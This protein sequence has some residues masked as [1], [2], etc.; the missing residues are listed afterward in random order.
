MTSL[1]NVVSGSTASAGKNL[2]DRLHQVFLSQQDAFR[3]NPY[4]SAAERRS[5]LLA[6]KN[7]LSR[8]QN[9]LAA[10]MSSD[11]GFRP[12]MESKLSDLLGSILEIN[13]LISHVGQWMKPSR[14]SP[15]HLFLTNSLTVVYQ[16]KGVVG[17]IVPWN[18]PIYLA[19]GP[20][21]SALAA[22]NRVM[23]KMPEAAPTTGRVLASMLREIFSEEE[24]AVVYTK[25]PSYDF[26]TSLPFNHIVFTGSPPSGKMVMKAAAEHLT[27]VTLELG[28]KSPAVVGRRYSTEDAARR[29]VHGK[30]LNCGQTCV[31]PDFAMVPAELIDD[32]VS[33]AKQSFSRLAGAAFSSGADY[34]WIINENRHARVLALLDD[35]QRKG[36]KVIPCADYSPEKDGRRMPLHLV[37]NCSAD[38]LILQEELF[39]PIL[40]VLAYSALD[41]VLELIATR[42]RPLALYLFSNDHDEQARFLTQTHSGGVTLNDWLCHVVNHDAPFGGVGNSGMGTYHGIEGFRE[43]S[44]AKTVFKLHRLFPTQLF[45]PPYGSLVQRFALRWFLGKPD[46]SLGAD[47]LTQKKGS[48]GIDSTS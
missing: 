29:I 4:P 12:P 16:P 45:H 3:T 17:I 1:S 25:L 19:L 34:T 43:L 23:M 5:K 18:F 40:P 27:P 20:L 39:G 24:V 36:A 21:A 46:E 35:A 33:A 42:P 14:R 26:F 48:L 38:M 31:A 7:Q 2:A 47:G 10:A 6:L 9:V 41:D 15:E 13:H 37:L 30:Y 8:Y 44:H 32:F 28:G 11:F 22:G